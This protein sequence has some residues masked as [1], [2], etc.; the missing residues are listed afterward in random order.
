MKNHEK[1]DSYKKKRKRNLQKFLTEDVLYNKL[2]IKK[3]QTKTIKKKCVDSSAKL[4]MVNL[5]DNIMN[6]RDSKKRITLGYSGTLTNTKCGNWNGYHRRDTKLYCMT[7][8]NIY[9]I[10][11]LHTKLFRVTRSLHPDFQVTSE[12]EPLILMTY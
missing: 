10:P 9:V 8:S 2:F 7:L 6:L 12:G 5:E 11:G 1:E 4:H 3:R